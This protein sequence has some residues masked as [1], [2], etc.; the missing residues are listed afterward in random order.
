[1]ATV[2]ASALVPASLAE[3]WDRYFDAGTWRAWVDGFEAVV[4]SDGYPAA[5]GTLH[6]RSIPAG[7]GEVTERVLEHEPRRLHRIAF[8]DPAMEG[9]LETRFQ[10][11]G[12]ATRVAQRLD[13]R[14]LARGPIARIGALLFVRAQVRASM[15]RSLHSLLRTVEEWA[16]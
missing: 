14:L 11:E 7:R 5:G 15:E 8:A 2:E 6:W 13:Y 12:D 16:P 1:M 3:T 4:D 10:I 9:E